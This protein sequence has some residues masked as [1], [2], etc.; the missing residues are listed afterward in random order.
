MDVETLQVGAGR[1]FASVST[2]SAALRASEAALDVDKLA[3]SGN[4]DGMDVDANGN[5]YATGAGLDARH[6]PR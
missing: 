6:R 2:L 3:V 4:L 5:V 1:P